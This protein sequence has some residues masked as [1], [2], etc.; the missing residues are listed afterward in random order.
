MST[1]YD[2]LM[3]DV[4]SFC[5]RTDKKTLDAIPQFITAAQ[6]DLDGE[7]SISEMISTVDY[8]ADT[9]SV[10]V[11]EFMDIESIT[12]GGLVG[13]STTYAEITA[14]RVLVSSRPETRGYDFHYAMNGNSVELV[15]ANS[16]VVTGL[17]KPP[18]LS[19]GNQTNAYTEGAENAL[20]WLSL[21][22]CAAFVKDAA[23]AQSWGDM[24]TGEVT[25]LNNIRDRFTKTGTAKVKRRGY[26]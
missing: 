5:Q 14:L 3:A 13:T 1:T 10:D 15:R 2:Q 7:L 22:Y 4:K 11:S 21:R 20:L 19:S 24:A 12:I 25:K 23:G 9:V 6:T 17:K 26:F 8:T 16:M 18:R